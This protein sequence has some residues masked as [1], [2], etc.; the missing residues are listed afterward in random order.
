[1]LVDEASTLTLPKD[2]ENLSQKIE[3]FKE[4]KAQGIKEYADGKYQAAVSK[5]Q[6]ARAIHKN[7]PE[8]LIYLNNAKAS[9]AKKTYTLAVV[10]PLKGD[11]AGTNRD[12]AMA[13]LKGA[14]HAQDDI[15]QS[16]GIAGVPIKLLII[17]DFNN[18][19]KSS[20]AVA[21][22]ITQQKDV[23]GIIGHDASNATAAARKIYQNASVAS[24]SP[25]SS[26]PAL[27]PGHTF[28]LRTIPNDTVSAKLMA[29]YMLYQD[30][31]KVAIVYSKGTD[32]ASNQY[33]QPV[34]DTIKEIL[35]I[36]DDL[37]E[38]VKEIN[39]DGFNGEQYD[40][41]LRSLEQ[42]IQLQEI[43]TIVLL[44]ARS[45]DSIQKALKLAIRSRELS[46]NLLILGNEAMHIPS[47]MDCA[48]KVTDMVVP[49]FWHMDTANANVST[50]ASDFVS[51]ASNPN[52]PAPLWNT[53]INWMSATTYDAV[54]AFSQA[55]ASNHPEAQRSNVAKSLTNEQFSM[56]G[57]T[58]LMKFNSSG[59]RLGGTMKL[60]KVLPN[61]NETSGED[62]EYTLQPIFFE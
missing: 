10:V 15:N 4:N 22:V 24:I 45:D 38:V 51:K 33:S 44:P 31:S 58:G 29:D 23:L 50:I 34:Q 7:S 19:P 60:F 28:G 8:S 16:G 42:S 55:L 39:L 37:E 5:F 49:M 6:A 59:D 56:D 35:D 20:E 14:A 2:T 17:D 30:R 52:H 1:M 13:I 47:V 36:N 18:N 46:K 41:L 53:S 32:D 57:V 3:E 21:K 27:P 12:T 11:V 26:S 62:S 54:L 25:T 48:Y 61:T 43:D 9:Q 40:E